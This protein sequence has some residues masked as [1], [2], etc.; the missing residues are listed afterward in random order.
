[1]SHI[2]RDE[3]TPR[4]PGSDGTEFHLPEG[5]APLPELSHAEKPHDVASTAEFVA[6]ADTPEY[7]KLRS[8]FRNFAFPMVT[9]G[10]VSFFAYVLMSMY[11]VDLMAKPFLGMK[12][13]N[14]GIFLGLCQFAMVYIWTA[15]YVRFANNKLDAT[16]ASIKAQLEKGAAA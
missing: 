5:H 9:A 13:L 2:H 6:M 8:T 10:L 12:G 1:M 11:A 3:E 14:L 7:A 4:P 15:L 16:S